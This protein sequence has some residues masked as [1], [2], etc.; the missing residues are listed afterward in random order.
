MIPHE[1]VAE[2]VRRTGKSVLQVATEM[3]RPSFQATLHKFIHGDVTSPS[4]A[5]A[6]RIST[7]FGIPTDALYDKAAARKVAEERGVQASASAP[8]DDGLRLSRAVQEAP[9]PYRVTG[10]RD[11]PD[12]LKARIGRLSDD[13]WQSLQ[14]VV[15]A[16]LD[17]VAPPGAGKAQDLDDPPLKSMLGR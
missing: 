11:F 12:S 15:T 7:Y 2:L 14:S 3:H 4:R 9:S 6:E 16:F 5:T 17:A 10:R 8:K 13:Q 1:L